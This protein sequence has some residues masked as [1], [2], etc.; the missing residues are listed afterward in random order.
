MTNTES[1][2]RSILLKISS[3]PPNY[4][5]QVDDYFKVVLQ[6]FTR[7]KQGNRKSILALE[8]GWNY[9]SESSFDEYLNAAKNTGKD[10]LQD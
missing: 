1:V 10:M 9:M 7:E 6:E 4:L 8:G 5:G 2:Y 3:L